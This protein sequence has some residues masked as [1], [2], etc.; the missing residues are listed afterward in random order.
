MVDIEKIKQ[1]EFVFASESDQEKYQLDLSDS[2]LTG[3]KLY[4]KLK[5]L[6]E[7]YATKYYVE[8]ITLIDDLDYDLCFRFLQSVEA[9]NPKLN[10]EDSLTHKVGGA[11]SKDHKEVKHLIPMLSIGNSMTHSDFMEF[12]DYIEESLGYAPRYTGELKYD[13]LSCGLRF[14]H[15]LLKQAVTRGDGETGED[16]TA[17]IQYVSDIPKF[18][19]NLKDIPFAEV[20]G[21]VYLSH[22]DFEAYNTK[23]IAQGKKTLANCRNGAA[24]GLRALDSSITKERNLRFFAY[25]LMNPEQHN[26]QTHWDALLLLKA[27]GFKV[28]SYSKLIENRAQAEDFYSFVLK[29]RDTVGLDIDGIVFKVNDYAQHSR[30]GWV[31]KTPRWATARKF[32][33][34]E[35]ESILENIELTVGRTGIITPVANLKPTKI[36]GVTVSN[37]TLYNFDEIVRLDLKIGDKVIIKRAG[38][39]IP[40]VVRPLV[41]KRVGTETAFVMPSLCPACGS[42]LFK[43]SEKVAY[44][45]LNGWHCKPQKLAAFVRFC[46]RDA[47]DIQGFGEQTVQRFLDAKLIDSLVDLKKLE[48]SSIA[49]MPDFGTASATKLVKAVQECVNVPLDKFIYALGIPAIGETASKQLAKKF[50]SLNNFLNATE[51]DLMAIDDFGPVAVQSVISCIYNDIWLDECLRLRSQYSPLEV[52]DLVDES[53][54]GLVFVITGTLTQSRDHYKSI[55]ENKG[56]KVSGS[57]SKKTSYVLVG[58]NAGTKLAEAEKLNIKILDE[59]SF[60]KLM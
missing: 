7:Y 39:V 52:A 11:A 60:E 48:V 22:A 4:P 12:F 2:K 32:P 49:N 21:E 30:L 27:W 38:D 53:F 36:G 29:N 45:C 25:S 20:R 35:A 51:S 59:A 15:G 58:E 19:E 1:I 33:A 54:K 9:E 18:I 3:L 16:V 26:V 17:Q 34:P 57:V 50:R 41:D 40:R 10:T 6:L 31:S 24:G 55:I 14:E 8:D 13:G 5:A 42:T 28:H 47:L 43:D 23:A 46:Q 44:K 37:A 56:G